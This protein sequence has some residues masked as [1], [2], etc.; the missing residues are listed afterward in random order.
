MRQEDYC[1]SAEDTSSMLSPLDFFKAIFTEKQIPP[2]DIFFEW[3]GFKV[4]DI[5]CLQNLFKWFDY[6]QEYTF[7]IYTDLGNRLTDIFDERLIASFDKIKFSLLQKKI[8][9]INLNDPRIKASHEDFLNF[10]FV[11]LFLEEI[12]KH[13]TS[14]KNLKALTALTSDFFRLGRLY[15]SGGIHVEMDQEA[16]SPLP[17]FDDLK[18]GIRLDSPTSYIAFIAANPRNTIIREAALLQRCCIQKVIINKNPADLYKA[19]SELNHRAVIVN[20]SGT[21]FSACLKNTPAEK[22]ITKSMQEYFK[23]LE[24]SSWASIEEFR[25]FQNNRQGQA[26]FFEF[27]ANMKPTPKQLK[28]ITL[29]AETPEI[30]IP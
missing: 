7:S 11:S 23:E 30:V 14:E 29:T 2:K 5:R 17:K 18:Y 4:T 21:V 8:T 12:K 3:F 13:Q 6:H 22:H 20:I 15:K 19:M 1:I 26:R 10:D 27:L 28:E 25:I 9:V 16:L 24:F